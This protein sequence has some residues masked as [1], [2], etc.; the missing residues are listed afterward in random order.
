MAGMNGWSSVRIFTDGIH[1][2]PTRNEEF[3]EMI[4]TSKRACRLQVCGNVECYVKM[5]M[6]GPEFMYD[7]AKTP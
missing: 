4:H 6:N 2:F 5:I 3:R 7:I 1:Y